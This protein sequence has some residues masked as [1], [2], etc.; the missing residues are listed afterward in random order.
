MVKSYFKMLKR[1]FSG[2]NGGKLVKD[3]LAGLTVAAVALPLALAFG[4]ASGASPAAGL[5][6][7]IIAGIV[8]SALSG[9]S[10]QISGPT[11]AMSAVL[12]TIAANVPISL[13]ICYNL[14]VFT[15]LA[16]NY[17]YKNFIIKTP[18]YA[19]ILFIYNYLVSLQSNREILIEN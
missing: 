8:I 14:Y 1:E 11:G 6:T 10:F 4:V 16:P 12:I 13:F 19:V 18:N 7:A 3:L 17:K 5:I 2:Y 9:A 15:I